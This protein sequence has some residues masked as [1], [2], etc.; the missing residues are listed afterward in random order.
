MKVANSLKSY[1][2]GNRNGGFEVNPMTFNIVCCCC[3]LKLNI[4]GVNCTKRHESSAPLIVTAI[5]TN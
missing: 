5:K 2:N 3:F 4:S 1:Q